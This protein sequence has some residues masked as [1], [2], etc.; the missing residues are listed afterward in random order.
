MSSLLATLPGIVPDG[1][2][3]PGLGLGGFVI[4]ISVAATAGRS[5]R[6]W[7]TLV[8]LC[9]WVVIAAIQGDWSGRAFFDRP[10]RALVISITAIVVVAA[11]AA[12]LRRS[13]AAVLSLAAC[14]GMWAIVPDT[15]APL[16]GGGVV[17][18]AT[19][20]A[21]LPGW[22]R[23]VRC[24]VHGLLLLL[25]MMGAATGTIGRP[26]RFVPGVFVGGLAALSGL[27]VWSL[28]AALWRRQRA[29]APMTVAPGRTSST[30][31]APAPTTA[32]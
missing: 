25:P 31:T 24:R 1:P 27:A 20:V 28:A 14:V 3:H 5:T 19:A 29:G 9:S 2:L 23:D 7:S 12:R 10:D 15:E 6:A 4:G 26:A 11:V 22:L 18:G 32:S 13:T 17:A 30:T 16:L 21:M 8:V